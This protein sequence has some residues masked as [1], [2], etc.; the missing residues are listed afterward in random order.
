MK[1]G[2][3]KMRGHFNEFVCLVVVVE[4]TEWKGTCLEW[5]RLRELERKTWISVFIT[6]FIIII[7]IIIILFCLQF[8]ISPNMYVC[9]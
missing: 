8:V 7:I 3:L 9:C 6:T 1:V 4:F 5:L 2:Y